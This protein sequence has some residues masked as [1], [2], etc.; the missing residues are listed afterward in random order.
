MKANQENQFR[1]LLKGGK[2]TV[3]TRIWTVQTFFVEGLG[4]TGHYDYSEFVAEYASYTLEELRNFCIASE[5]HG[6]S[7]M[8]KVDFQNR[9]FVAQKAIASGFQAINFADCRSAEEVRQAIRLTTA[10]TP[11][12]GGCFGF[13]NNRFIGW[14]PWTTQERHADRLKNIV[15]CFMIEK[16]S[17]MDELDEVLSIPGVDMVQFGP[18]DYSL[19]SGFN[20]K[21]RVEDVEAVERHLIKSAIKHNVRPR[22]EIQNVEDAKYYMDLGVRDFS[23]G[24]QMKLLMRGWNA[25]GS[26]IRKML[27]DI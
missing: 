14:E 11:E 15:R 12:D 7:S 8:I 26:G 19:S 16:K 10:E 23:M 17:I 25:D 1:N 20:F 2:P 24:D 27:Q 5:L 6:M 9:G 21:D 4:S 13:P 3:G 22:C 18:S